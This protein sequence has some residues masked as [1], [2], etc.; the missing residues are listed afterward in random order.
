MLFFVVHDEQQ[1]IGKIIRRLID[2]ENNMCCSPKKVQRILAKVAAIFVIR[3]NIFIHVGM[4]ASL[5]IT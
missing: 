3:T 5:N 2:N 4:Y 1:Y